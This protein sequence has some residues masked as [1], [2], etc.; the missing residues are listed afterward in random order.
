MRISVAGDILIEWRDD[1]TSFMSV[2][3]TVEGVTS[4]RSN[5]VISSSDFEASGSGSTSDGEGLQA[6]NSTAVENLNVTFR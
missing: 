6:D 1:F 3:F 2:T 5:G 4:S